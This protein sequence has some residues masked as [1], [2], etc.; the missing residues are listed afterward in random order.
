MYLNT[1]GVKEHRLPIENDQVDPAVKAARSQ[2]LIQVQEQILRTFL[3]AFIN[4]SSQVLY[5]EKSVV[6]NK[7][8]YYGYTDNYIKVKVVCDA[9]IQNKLLPTRIVDT[10]E[11]MLIGVL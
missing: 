5:E 2:S 6:G 10:H 1:L 3:E 11:D 7:S 4:K 8:Y 9:D